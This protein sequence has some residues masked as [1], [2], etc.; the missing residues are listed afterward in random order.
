MNFVRLGASLSG[1]PSSFWKVKSLV[2]WKVSLN[3]RLIHLLD[4]FGVIFAFG[5]QFLVFGEDLFFGRFEDAIEAAQHGERDHDAAVLRWAV[6]TPEEV[7]DVPDYIAVCFEGI[8]II[9]LGY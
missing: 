7:G 2:L 5:F 8:K 1:S 6:G 4:G 9:H 3:F